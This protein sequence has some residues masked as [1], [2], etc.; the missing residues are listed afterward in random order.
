L[1]SLDL[2]H[3]GAYVLKRHALDL[4]SNF[5]MLV[6]LFAGVAGLVAWVRWNRR[7]R[8]TLAMDQVDALSKKL[9]AL[10]AEVG[11]RSIFATDDLR[12][13]L[14]NRG[15]SRD[16]VEVRTY[17]VTISDVLPMWVNF[18]QG[19]YSSL[20]QERAKMLADILFGEAHDIWNHGYNMI[21]ERGSLV[22]ESE[23]IDGGYDK[24][25]VDHMV[26]IA[27][28]LTQIYL[29][30]HCPSS[31]LLGTF[32]TANLF[33]TELER[34]ADGGSVEALKILLLQFPDAKS[35]KQA[36]EV[37]RKSQSPE[38][39]VTLAI[40]ADKENNDLLRR[41]A[42]DKST[43]TGP[44]NQAIAELIRREDKEVLI[45][46]MDKAPK[47][48]I[49]PLVRAMGNLDLSDAEPMLIWHLSS[50]D[51]E[52]VEA[53]VDALGKVGGR[54]SIIPL[55]ERRDKWFVN[56]DLEIAIDVAIS[57]IQDRL[58]GG[59]AG[60]LALVDEIRNQGQL[61]LTD[62]ESGRLALAAKQTHATKK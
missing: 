55:K 18:H 5:W 49:I 33:E 8:F 14:R 47:A 26:E 52:L 61:S 31:G 21:G 1:E 27:I 25:I 35:T 36:I 28:K 10:E 6:P 39:K 50:K 15:N 13:E 42:I 12:M 11:G 30:R 24:E 16:E 59:G 3:V 40:H 58:A 41:L 32:P 46:V 29:E 45:Q 37:A 34:K 57:L 23:P 62:S 2:F 53:A 56:D 19:G 22:I 51:L 54:D 48:S 20:Q 60:G 44:C 17:R 7:R 9:K 4:S 38:I 43:P